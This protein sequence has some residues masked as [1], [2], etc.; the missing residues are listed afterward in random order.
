MFCKNYDSD[1]ENCKFPK[2]SQNYL[3]CW[4]CEDA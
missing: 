2:E 4:E 3:K 1:C